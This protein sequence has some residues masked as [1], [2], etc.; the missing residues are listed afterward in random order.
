MRV[1][2]V[3]DERRLNLLLCERFAKEGYCVDSCLDGAEAS[4]FIK[5]A[6]YDAMVLDIMLPGKDGIQILRE[7][8][9][10]GV[11]TPVLLL[12]ARGQ[13]DD[14]VAGL[15][16][17]ADDY[18][19]KPFAMDELLARVRALIRRN[20]KGVSNT[21]QVADLVIDC[22]TRAVT[23]AGVP[24]TLSKKEFAILEL[25]ARRAGAVIPQEKI[26]T[27]IWNYDYEGD[28]NIV[29]VYIRYLRRKID[30]P[31]GVKLIRTVRGCGYALQ[32]K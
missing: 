7:T 23:R 8:R 4:A 15:D 22:D 32:E 11:K 31:F 20:T 30:E 13:T 16:A 21:I 28:S 14:R 26:R 5:G 17:G 19:P 3:E 10:S 9:A 18:L 12:T 25:L 27:H 2:V 6:E 29:N 1:L 24:I